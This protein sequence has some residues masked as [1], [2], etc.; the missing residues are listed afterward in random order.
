MTSQILSPEEK[1][2][3]L[4]TL[5]VDKEFRYAVAGAIG[6]LEI[7]R[8]LDSIESR[9]EEHSKTLQEHSK[10][11]EDHSKRIEE[12]TKR[13]EE[14]TKRVEELTKRVEQHSKVLERHSKVLEEHSKRLE[15]LSKAVYEHSIVLREHGKKI[16]V[17]SVA[18]GSI[19][20][21]MGVDLEKMVYS[22]YRDMLFGVGIRDVDKI[23][24]FIYVDS[25]GRYFK[26]GTKIEVDVYAHNDEVY[27][28]EVK[29]LV[30]EDDVTW[31]SIKCDAVSN[32]LGKKIKRKVIV[33]I[34]VVR[35]ALEKAKDLGIDIIYGAVVE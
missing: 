30:E 16:D 24:K 4:R 14:L 18:I 19:G 5:E 13:V 9:I 29:S 25:E 35:E 31:F 26:K 15:E 8:R 1:E 20:R 21:R 2:R 22:I 17:L 3:F 27:V 6:L 28:I 7:L 32:I 33:A 12:L 23:E 11:L 10:I 34:N